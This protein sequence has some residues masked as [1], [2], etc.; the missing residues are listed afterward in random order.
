MKKYFHLN[1]PTVYN[2]SAKNEAV[3][4][5]SIRWLIHG[6]VFGPSHYICEVKLFSLCQLPKVVINM[7]VKL[8]FKRDA[9]N[10]Q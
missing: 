3:K 6:T 2:S 4:E 5:T 1:S 10:K 9:W 8:I 7:T